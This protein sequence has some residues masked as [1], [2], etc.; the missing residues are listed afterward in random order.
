MKKAILVL[1]AFLPCALAP[2]PAQ[3][4]SDAVRKELIECVARSGVHCTDV[5]IQTRT[6]KDGKLNVEGHCL[7]SFGG[8]QTLYRA[9]LT[10][11]DKGKVE[12]CK[13]RVARKQEEGGK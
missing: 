12:S 5:N 8:V 2:A 13:V 7:D 3:A 1:A 6:K 10:D 9:V 11:E 4:L